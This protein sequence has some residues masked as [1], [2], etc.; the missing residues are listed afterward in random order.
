MKKARVEF[1]PLVGH[2]Q[3]RSSR[4][5]VAVPMLTTAALRRAAVSR[6]TLESAHPDY[7]MTE[8]VFPLVPVRDPVALAEAAAVVLKAVGVVIAVMVL[9]MVIWSLKGSA[10]Q[11]LGTSGWIYMSSS[12]PLALP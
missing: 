5:T 1:E 9:T 7:A 3:G 12:L 6:S 11:G 2:F 10:H 4:S 8:T